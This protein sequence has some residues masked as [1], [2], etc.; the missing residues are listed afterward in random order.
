MHAHAFFCMSTSI[1][2]RVHTFPKVLQKT[3][4]A[5]PSESY[6]ESSVH[7]RGRFIRY[8]HTFSRENGKLDTKF[9]KTAQGSPRLQHSRQICTYSTACSGQ[10]VENRSQYRITNALCAWQIVSNLMKI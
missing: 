5:T 9:D 1:S 6:V 10:K 4:P 8:L 3:I 2:T 7:R